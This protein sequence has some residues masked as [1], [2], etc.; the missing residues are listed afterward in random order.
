MSSTLINE[1]ATLINPYFNYNN[2]EWN[3]LI[4]TETPLVCILAKAQTTAQVRRRSKLKEPPWSSLQSWTLI[5]LSLVDST[6]KLYLKLILLILWLPLNSNHQ[7]FQ[8]DWEQWPLN[9]SISTLIPKLFSIQATSYLGKKKK[10]QH[11]KH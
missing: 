10:I 7:N 8:L 11:I 4:E 2:W 6:F 9:Y 3:D 1:S 5:Q